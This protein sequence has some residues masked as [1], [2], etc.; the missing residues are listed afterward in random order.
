HQLETDIEP[1]RGLLLG[2]LF[3]AVG[4]SVAWPLILENWTLVLFGAL[5]L[6]AVK[7]AVLYALARVF[8]S[9]N[10][11]SLKI[12]AVLGQGGEFGFVMF[13]VSVAAGVL[14]QNESYLLTAVVTGTMALTPLVIALADKFAERKVPNMEGIDRVEQAEAAQ[15]IVVGFGRF[16]QIV[17]RVMK[18]RGYDVTLID[19][20]PDRIRI[21]RTFGNKVFFG[22]IGRGDILRTVGAESA[23]AVFLCMDDPDAISQGVRALRWRFPHLTI[24]ARAHDRVAELELYKSGADVVVREMLESGVKM[25]R[26]ALEK[27][28]DGDI[29][30]ETIEEFRRRDAELLRYQSEFGALGGYEKMREEF[31]LKDS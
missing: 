28:G 21:A 16:G 19:S 8:R 15:V 3:I 24:Y 27:F 5:A 30:D 6:V 25:A 23:K 13:T 2:L 10:G 12:S 31:D 11:D 29:A 20:S 26:M 4:M 18:L 7:C 22:D 1:F 9:S 14:T 17:G